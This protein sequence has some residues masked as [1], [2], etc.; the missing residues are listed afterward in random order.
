MT[1]VL[2][3]TILAEALHEASERGDLAFPIP[4]DT[5]PIKSGC[6]IWSIKKISCYISMPKR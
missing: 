4:R 6:V 3:K 1:S 5:V 2:K